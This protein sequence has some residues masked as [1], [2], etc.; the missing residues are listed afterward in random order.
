MAVDTRDKRASAI[1]PFSLWRYLPLPD[2]TIDT[3]DRLH[4]KAYRGIAAD[5]AAAAADVVP[6]VNINILR[7]MRRR[8]WRRYG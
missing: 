5:A 2:A 1:G 6:N 3:D 4:L 8:D 7:M